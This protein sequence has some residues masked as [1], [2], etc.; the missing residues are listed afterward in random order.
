V[1]SVSFSLQISA[2]YEGQI[3]CTASFPD[4]NGANRVSR[5]FTL[6]GAST[7]FQFYV[8]SPANLTFRITDGSDNDV[9]TFTHDTQVAVVYTFSSQPLDYVLLQFVCDG[10]KYH[11]YGASQQ[12]VTDYFNI[13]DG[14]F[15]PVGTITCAPFLVGPESNHYAVQT[16]PI[17]LTYAGPKEVFVRPLDGVSLKPVT[18]IYE[19]MSLQWE[20]TLTEA[21]TAGNSVVITLTCSSDDPSHAEGGT[22]QSSNIATFN[23]VVT[24]QTLPFVVTAGAAFSFSCV[25]SKSET[26]PEFTASAPFFTN[27]FNTY[28]QALIVIDVTFPTVYT[29]LPAALTV[30]AQQAPLAPIIVQGTCALTSDNLQDIVTIDPIHI[31]A[32]A[33]SPV[34]PPN[35]LTFTQ[36]GSHDCTFSLDP[37]GLGRQQFAVPAPQTVTVINH[38]SLMIIAAAPYPCYFGFPCTMQLQ[39][40]ALPTDVMSVQLDC[41]FGQTPLVLYQKD[42]YDIIVSD[43]LL[44]VAQQCHRGSAEMTRMQTM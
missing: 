39:P 20:I 25:Y 29:H 19:G 21:P 33:S 26:T 4:Q 22:F 6:D 36:A 43:Q 9:T 17:T 8:Y 44:S 32:G 16:A 7:N 13:F 35:P 5:G 10:V 40:Q 30:Y 41:G 28:V 3:Y 11:E 34:N 38:G 24:L 18:T 37:S 23:S 1:L 27:G 42:K 15:L 12:T 31:N 2:G 14:S